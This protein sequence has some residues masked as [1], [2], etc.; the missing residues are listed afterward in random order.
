MA[1]Y[2]S[3]YRMARRG[4][5]EFYLSGKQ[6]TTLPKRKKNTSLSKKES[7]SQSGEERRKGKELTATSFAP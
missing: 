6:Q 2:S 4:P 7:V 5:I 1:V 3:G